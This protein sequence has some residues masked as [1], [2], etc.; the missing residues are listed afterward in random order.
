MTD[1]DY[2]DED[3]GRFLGGATDDAALAAARNAIMHTVRTLDAAV[4]DLRRL[5]KAAD[6]DIEAHMPTHEPDEH[7][8][9]WQQGY[10]AGR[11]AAASGE[12]HVLSAILA[13]AQR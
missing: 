2:T 13:R 7:R 4:N 5:L 9:A 8:R 11:C 10:A 12:E 1:P 6:A 3:V